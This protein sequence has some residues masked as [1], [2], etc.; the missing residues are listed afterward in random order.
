MDFGNV[1]MQFGLPVSVN[2]LGIGMYS[3][4][5]FYLHISLEHGEVFVY[6]VDSVGC[7]G[8]VESTPI[9]QL[10]IIDL[11]ET[12]SLYYGLETHDKHI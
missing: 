4:S 3:N 6:W 10:D 5:G 2:E 9:D 11:A 12:L 8:F 1:L 7:E